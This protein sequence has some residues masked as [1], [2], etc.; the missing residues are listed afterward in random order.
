VSCAN[1]K[2]DAAKRKR[3]EKNVFFIGIILE[4]HTEY[5]RVIKI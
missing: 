5:A 3:K 4:G 2:P 1:S